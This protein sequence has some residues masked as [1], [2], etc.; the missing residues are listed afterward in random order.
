MEERLGEEDEMHELDKDALWDALGAR[1]FQ[2]ARELLKSTGYD[3]EDL[4]DLVREALD[5]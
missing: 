3:L 2:L 1:D 4:G 5:E